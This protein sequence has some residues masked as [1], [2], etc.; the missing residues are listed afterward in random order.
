MSSSGFPDATNTGVPASTTLTPA[1]GMTIRTAGAV[2]SGLNITGMVTISASN[3]T[4]EN[5]KIS[6]DAYA[7]IVVQAGATGVTIR[8]CEIYGGGINGQ[9]N[10]GSLGIAIFGGG[11]TVLNCNIYG[12]ANGVSINSLKYGPVLI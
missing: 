4:L 7:S 8:N 9:N 11:V 6:A 5:C 2:V 1:A 12:S 3:V 10:E